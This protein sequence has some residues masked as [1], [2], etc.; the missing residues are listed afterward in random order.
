MERKI[1]GL[2]KGIHRSPTSGETGE[3]MEC[4]NLVVRDNEIMNAPILTDIGIEFPED[5]YELRYIHN[6]YLG[7]LYIVYKDNVVSYFMKEGGSLVNK[8]ICNAPDLLDITSIGNILIVLCKKSKIFAICKDGEYKILGNHLPELNLQF[9]LLNDYHEVYERYVS[10]NG[11]YRVLTSSIIG[12][13][14]YDNDIVYLHKQYNDDDDPSELKTHIMGEVDKMIKEYKEMGYFMAPFFVRYAY[15]LY[16]GSNIMVS[17]PVMMM[18]NSG[19]VPFVHLFAKPTYSS[20][21]DYLNSTSATLSARAYSLIYKEIGESIKDELRNWEDIIKGVDIYV[22]KQFFRYDSGGNKFGVYQN[23]NEQSSSTA[24]LFATKADNTE[25]GFFED[26][27]SYREVYASSLGGVS[28]EITWT[29]TWGVPIC[30][31]KP[32]EFNKEIEECGTYYKIAEIEIKELSSTYN[33]VKIKD[34]VLASLEG[35]KVLDESNELYS[36][37]LLV[38]STMFAFNN[39]LHQANFSRV[40]FDGYKPQV[41]HQDIHTITYDE[42]FQPSYEEVTKNIEFN[43]WVK[44]QGR[45][46][47]LPSSGTESVSPKYGKDFY[48]FYPNSNGVQLEITYDGRKYFFPMKEC[49]FM[50]GSYVYLGINKSFVTEG[51]STGSY[52]S[53]GENIFAYSNRMFT[54]E[55]NNPFIVNV[56][57]MNNVGDGE[58]K[59]ICTISKA[60]S[61]GQFGAFPMIAFSTDGIWALQTNEKG[62]FS[63]VQPLSREIILDGT[64]PCQTDSDIIYASAR[65][66]NILRGSESICISDGLDGIKDMNNNFISIPSMSEWSALVINESISFDSIINNAKFVY[67]SSN[68]FLHLYTNDNDVH[69]ICNLKSYEWTKM[70]GGKPTSIIMGYPYT[71]I[72]QGKKVKRY[73]SLSEIDNDSLNI[74]RKGL[75]LTREISFDNPVAKKLLYDIR[76]LHKHKKSNVK[77]AVWVS[78]DRDNWKL[79]T[80]LKHSSWIWYRFAIFT[81][82]TDVEGLEGMICDVDEKFTNKIR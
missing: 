59:S 80:S 58:V 30:Q 47:R 71:F 37:D 36:H 66:I 41:L 15:R 38:P 77:I 72:Q 22:S 70:Q 51:A 61:Q 60:L 75:L 20:P 56:N 1:I 35:Q 5:G 14:L 18:A 39:R 34:G 55:V 28:G 11:K 82:M 29:H 69:Y 68:G 64:K 19:L 57:G 3:L 26:N 8:T 48:F 16:D 7:K 45:Y 17:A 6:S 53:K 73:R 78:D 49:T 67:D 4:M 32:E 31:K 2:N 74:K 50:T 79:L 63:A 44:E 23:R 10:I 13:N 62:L 76:V 40:L 25:V 33:K 12:E 46:L 21:H 52:T 81:D 27:S 54:S 65:G 9:S 42:N 24:L 43:V